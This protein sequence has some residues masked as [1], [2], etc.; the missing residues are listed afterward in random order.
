MPLGTEREHEHAATFLQAAVEGR[1]VR[2]RL[3][4]GRVVELA[5]LR[6]LPVGD[7]IALGGEDPKT[8]EARSVSAR[9]VVSIETI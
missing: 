3:T 8:G 9:D 7:D 6:V 2:L 5:P 4:H 1:R